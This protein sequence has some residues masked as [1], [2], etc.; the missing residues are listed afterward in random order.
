MKRTVF[1]AFTLVVFG[2]LVVGSIVF[3]YIEGRK[4]RK[5]KQNFAVKHDDFLRESYSLR[6]K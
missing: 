5:V 1:I 4:E 2:Y 6:R 3:H